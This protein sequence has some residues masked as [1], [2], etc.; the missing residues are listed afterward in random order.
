[1]RQ[2]WVMRLSFLHTIARA[3][4]FIA[5]FSEN[6]PAADSCDPIRTFADGKQPLRGIFV[7]PTGSN[8]TGDGTQANPYQTISRALQGIQ[9]GDAIRLLP[10][11]YTAGTSIGNLAGTSNA[12]IWLG[13][14]PG[15]ARPVISGGSVA[16]QL[17]RV[18]FLILENIEVTG[19]TGNGIN[20]DDGGEY[21]NT[22]ATRHLLFRNLYVHDI[23]TGGNNDGLKLSGVNDYF[24]LDCEFARMSA[25]GSGIDHVGCHRGWIAR[26]TFTD[27]GGNAI[28]CKGGSEDIEIRW[29]R[30]LNGGGRAINIG[31]STG[32]EFFRPPLSTNSPN[33]EAKNIRVIANLFRGWDAPIAFVGTVNSLAANNTIVQPR[34]WV[35]RILQETVSSGGYAF[36][37]CAQNQF[38]NNLVY[39]DRSQISTHVNIGSNTDA[40]S[41]GFAHNL[42]YAFNQPNQSQPI[43]PSMETNGVYALNPL[44]NNSAAGDYSV[45]T[46]SPAVGRGRNLSNSKADL[47]EHCYADPPTLG[48]FEGVP[49]SPPRADADGDLM[50]DAWEEAHN[51]DKD[52]PADA[53][54][55]GDGD[56]LSNVGEYLAGTDPN[57]SQSVFAVRSPAIAG[58]DFSFRYSALTG[59]VYRVQVRDLTTFTPWLEIS[60]TNGMGGEVEFRQLAASGAAKM[61]R[62]AL[63]LAP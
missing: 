5:V 10:G 26:C 15:Q 57:D 28:Q 49:P 9:P 6:C 45:A 46:N 20:C 17:S 27:A 34:R 13:G 16:L 48:A 60:V 24:V 42:W 61:F 21:A 55:D 36:L 53:P 63:E 14:V 29:N 11:T 39:F 31:G 18:R 43:L 38:I 58:G 40:T 41:F 12:P 32:F 33:F 19:A 52:D 22:N 3:A 51:L 7:S 8:S 56:G 23:G 62:V 25:G 54:L 30:I 35:L 50:P 37:P 44:F 47:L 1:M 2:D 59:R 4:L